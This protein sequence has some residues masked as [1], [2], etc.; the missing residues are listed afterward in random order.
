MPV[1]KFDVCSNALVLIG[2]EEIT[3]FAGGSTESLAA[4]RFFQSTVDNFLTLYDWQFATTTAQIS[5]LV[6][7]P[8]NQWDAAYQ[9]PSGAIKIQNVK[10]NDKPIEY[11][12]YKDKIHCNA[13]ASDTVFCDYTFSALVEDWPPY[14]TELI[15]YALARKFSTALAAKLDFKNSFEIDLD[16]QFRLAKNADARQQTTKRLNM[17]GPGSIIAMRRS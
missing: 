16:R 7:A 6:D 3:D 10:V 13:A 14:F 1:T 5:R 11:D 15:E 4:N 17:K 12:R 2:A 8:L 9:Q